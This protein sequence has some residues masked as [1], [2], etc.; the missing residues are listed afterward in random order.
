V[1]SLSRYERRILA[2]FAATLLPKTDLLSETPEEVGLVEKV[3]RHLVYL[4]RNVRII[5]RLTLFLFEMGGMFYRGRPFS[6]LKGSDRETYLLLWKKSGLY[7]MRLLSKL[8]ESV[9]YM[10][11]YAD[12]EVG[13]KLGFTP[14]PILHR[15][16]PP[17]LH[18]IPDR[19]LFLK[20]DVCVIGSGAGGAVVAKELAEKGRS[21]VIL[22]E[23]GYFNIN[24]FGKDPLEI[25][26][27]IY[28]NGGLQ[29]TFGFPCILLPTGRAVGGTTIINS[30]TCFRLPEKVFA[31]WQREFGLNDITP[32][33]LAPYFDRVERHLNVV[34]VEEDVLGN[35]SKVFR[36]GL[37]KLG[38]KGSPL[39]RNVKDCKGSGM[40]CFGCPTDAKQSVHLSYIPRAIEKGA[41][42]FVRCRAE[43]LFPRQEHGGEVVGRFR[44]P[45]TGRDGKTIRIDAKVIV[46]AAGTLNTPYLLRKNHIA[47]FN[48]HIGRH[49]TIH[50]A[51]KVMALFDEEIRG[52]EG[53]PQGFSFDG[54]AS[55]G[56]LFEGA[57]TPPS[58]SSI[59]LSL[60]PR[61][62]KEVMEKF[63]HLA[64][65]GFLMSDEGRGWIRWL[66]NGDPIAYYSIRRKEVTKFVKAHRFL[67][68]VFL[69]AGAKK[70]FPCLPGIPE[71]TSADELKKFDEV[72]IWRRDLE[73]SA[74]HPL[75]T[76]RMGADPDQSVVNG[77]GEMHYV[78]NLFIADGSIFPSPLSVNPQETIMAFANRTADYIHERLS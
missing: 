8:I 47:I 1:I 52:W 32:E 18:D 51:S 53:V 36:R 29:V 77:Y 44:D 27:K 70:V 17:P 19:D 68:E 41:K 15:S 40:C 54:M 11:Y 39:R 20:A 25:L 16:D 6:F 33:G 43:Y 37:E 26:Q 78:K 61:L 3:Q 2:A 57:F 76:C 56:I 46:L 31:R 75:G 71:V 30:G 24:D 60:P 7:S 59:N 50:P 4:P 49:L 67:T 35:N 42:L 62:H 22:E 9:C 64:A 72:R 45:I 28:R 10:D 73:L 12:P 5:F 66:P 69:A 74:F 34:P 21:V 55:D 23:G 58:A 63:R 14:P 38:F 13:R 48:R 65:F